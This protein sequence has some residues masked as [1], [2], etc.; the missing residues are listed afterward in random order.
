VLYLCDTMQPQSPQVN[1][2][3]FFISRVKRSDLK[4][5]FGG[6][7]FLNI[8]LK[9]PKYEKDSMPCCGVY[10]FE[11]CPCIPPGVDRLG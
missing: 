3:D 7:H 2:S 1:W 5:S 8:V 11:R 9:W 4:K 6:S 10:R